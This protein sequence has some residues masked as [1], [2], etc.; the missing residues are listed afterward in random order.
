MATAQTPSKVSTNPVASGERTS[1]AHGTVHVGCRD[2]A[3]LAPLARRQQELPSDL[4]SVDAMCKAS[5]A[6][7]VT[8]ELYTVQIDL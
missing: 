4:R 1:G 6:E 2:E 3:V 5:S 8:S 7:A